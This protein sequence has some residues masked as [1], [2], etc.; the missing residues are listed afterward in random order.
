MIM[1]VDVIN[2]KFKS[3]VLLVKARAEIITQIALAFISVS[4]RDAISQV[5]KYTYKCINW[6]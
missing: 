2:F 1:R 5:T 6:V 3:K 4:S